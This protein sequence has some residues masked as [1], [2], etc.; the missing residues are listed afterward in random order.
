M[1]IPTWWPIITNFDAVTTNVSR[2][3]NHFRESLQL[4]DSTLLK[5]YIF[6][7][8]HGDAST[9]LNDPYGVV[10]TEKAAL[11]YFGHTN[12]LGKTLNF[13]S[14]GGDK[15]DFTITAV[16]DNLPG[17]SVTNLSANV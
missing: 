15:H 3:E 7:L 1:L 5:M 10:I 14:F 12:V 17:N 6:K 13:E 16:L 11:K 2:G 8:L 4:G 9:A